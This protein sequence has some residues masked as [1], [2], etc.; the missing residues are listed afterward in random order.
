MHIIAV[1]AIIA[2]VI[3]AVIA[4]SVIS[5]NN[6]STGGPS[7]TNGSNGNN[8]TASNT[9]IALQPGQASAVAIVTIH[10]THSIFHVHYQLFLNADL[11][12]EGDVAAHSSVIN[13]VTIVFPANQTGLYKA[14]VLATS[15][16][17]GF[18]DKSDQAVV[19]PVD[20]GTYPI[21][22]DV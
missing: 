16:G 17:G 19:T 14:V 12:A 11:Q 6:N 22:L 13:T 5:S 15:T 4:L 7:S 18:G 10:S 9:S 21:T 2:V 8:L 3:I 1:V 20:G